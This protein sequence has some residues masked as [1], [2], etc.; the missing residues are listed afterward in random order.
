[1]KEQKPSSDANGMDGGSENSSSLTD[2]ERPEEQESSTEK[3]VLGIQNIITG[4]TNG[5][6]PIP[7]ELLDSLS[8]VLSQVSDSEK[9][10]EIYDEKPGSI[11]DFTGME[12]SAVDVKETSNSTGHVSIADLGT[13]VPEAFFSES[14]A[15]TSSSVDRLQDVSTLTSV[16][17]GSRSTTQ[18]TILVDGA[19][20][21]Q[22]DDEVATKPEPISEVIKN[23]RPESGSVSEE[24]KWEMISQSAAQQTGGDK[25]EIKSKVNDS[26]VSELLSSDVAAVSETGIRN[27]TITDTDT[28]SLETTDTTAESTDTDVEH[29]VTPQESDYETPLSEIGGAIATS[30]DAPPSDV[31]TSAY[32]VNASEVATEHKEI[33]TTVVHVVGASEEGATTGPVP[34]GDSDKLDDELS[35]EQEES[36]DTAAVQENVAGQENSSDELLSDGSASGAS[37]QVHSA[38]E[39]AKPEEDATIASDS[40]S[41]YTITPEEESD[42]IVDVKDIAA[43]SSDESGTTPGPEASNAASELNADKT[44]NKPPVT[45]VKGPEQDTITM[46]METTYSSGLKDESMSGIPVDTG[47]L[48]VSKI[49]SGATSDSQNDDLLQDPV[50]ESQKLQG[51]PASPISAMGDDFNNKVGP[52]AETLPSDEPGTGGSESVGATKISVVTATSSSLESIK[53]SATVSQEQ[54]IPGEGLGTGETSVHVLSQQVSEKSPEFSLQKLD[55]KPLVTS[56]G[57]SSISPLNRDK[58]DAS[59][60]NDEDGS[61]VSSSEDVVRTTT[62]ISDSKTIPPPTGSS[63]E[64]GEFTITPLPAN[65]ATEMKEGQETTT[66]SKEFGSS[67]ARISATPD[68]LMSTS[69]PSGTILETAP[70]LK[71]VATDDTAVNAETNLP[72]QADD[73]DSLKDDTEEIKPLIKNP[74]MM[75]VTEELAT[76]R[77]PDDSLSSSTSDRISATMANDS[78]V[79]LSEFAAES[80]E[81]DTVKSTELEPTGG[82][83]SAEATATPA[84]MAGSSGLPEEGSAATFSDSVTFKYQLAPD[85]SNVNYQETLGMNDAV[86]ADTVTAPNTSTQN[87]DEKT[88]EETISADAGTDELQASSSSN[89]LPGTVLENDASDAEEEDDIPENTTPI[90]ESAESSPNKESDAQKTGLVDIA[91]TE[92]TSSLFDKEAQMVSANS[93]SASESLHSSETSLSSNIKSTSDSATDSQSEEQHGAENDS[94][95]E[96][97]QEDD[98][99]YSGHSGEKIAAKL[100]DEASPGVSASGISVVKSDKLGEGQSSLAASSQGDLPSQSPGGSA[101]DSTEADVKETATDGEEPIFVKINPP[102]AV[103]GD[104]GDHASSEIKKTKIPVQYH[105]AIDVPSGIHSVVAPTVT[106]SEEVSPTAIR[107]EKPAYVVRIEVPDRKVPTGAS[108][109]DGAVPETEDIPAVSVPEYGDQSQGQPL[110]GATGSDGQ[111]TDAQHTFSVEDSSQSQRPPEIPSAS[112]SIIIESVTAQPA[113]PAQSSSPAGGLLP[114]EVSW[115]E[116]GEVEEP[117]RPP[118]DLRPADPAH[119]LGLEATTAALDGDVRAFADLLNELALRLWAGV[120]ARG[121]N[122]ASAP[123]RSLVLSPFALTSLLAMVFL[124]ARGPTSDQM[125][126]LLRLD[127]VVTFNPHL[128]LRNV[129]DSLVHGNP[130]GV[131]AVA[132]VRQ[133]YSDKSK[134]KLLEFYKERAQQWY[135]GHVEEADWS[136][137]GDLVRRRTNLLVRR[138]TRG[139]VHEFVRGAGLALRPPLAAFTASVFQTDCSGASTE[140]RDGEMYFTVSPSPRQRRLVPVPAAVW[141]EG[142]HAGYDPHIDATVAAIGADTPVSVVLALPGQQGQVA[143]GDGLSALER[144]LLTPEGWARAL[145]CVAPRRGLQLQA[146]R[147][148]HRSLLNATAALRRL[149]LRDL[150]T[151]GRADLRGLSGGLA[152]LHLADVLAATQLSTCAGHSAHAEVFPQRAAG[153][154]RRLDYDDT[155]A[156][157]L[158]L[159]LA[160]RPRQAR[161]PAAAAR[162]S[163]NRPFFY[164]VRHNPTGIILHMGRFNPRLIH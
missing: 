49:D 50:T 121:L 77:T 39:T 83:S 120:A 47:D 160:L 70:S 129:T 61:K 105:S 23:S 66:P 127:D 109:G 142:V 159:P 88:P 53:D 78:G 41:S 119:Q 42:S 69:Q 28:L 73:K 15:Q 6:G 103:N 40:V 113:A 37:V 79:Y 74:T 139:R 164:A 43:E 131:A 137:V 136:A 124:G 76:A 4:D 22:K 29:F 52:T 81:Q 30:A 46:E 134:G 65:I 112:P 14:V 117:E 33:V 107:D 5:G 114:P 102:L 147:F 13:I 36:A 153:R 156:E 60:S 57:D 145:R 3:Y 144:R 34:T 141:S 71:V 97:S 101:P 27:E 146:P 150:L 118:V 93:S 19:N 162:L 67:T 155:D 91:S 148:A 31:L 63:T 111:P 126:D 108:E 104:A 115:P 54:R 100:S 10:T 68:S 98:E 161:R 75:S 122:T 38:P 128:V 135:E 152:D 110:E 143:P 125:N 2:T 163:F 86:N 62:I 11:S 9:V 94:A 64:S 82:P 133:L 132:F 44:K 51:A 48:I 87:T 140:G 157:V 80:Q 99:D 12:L 72:Q 95:A 1:M 16:I 26:S 154:A 45:I 55:E 7:V 25:V 32:D 149:G 8:S 89:N 138:Q 96:V 17:V 58:D 116:E 35:S 20:A 18:S 92:S 158:Q 84:A 24:S 90:L 85:L 59:P 130:P 123:P 56:S 106:S 151:R 21:G